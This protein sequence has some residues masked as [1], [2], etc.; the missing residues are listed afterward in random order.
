MSE[1]GRGL[2]LTLR[3]IINFILWFAAA[4]AVDEWAKKLTDGKRI[5]MKLA[6]PVLLVIWF[7]AEMELR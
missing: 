4:Y 5:M 2:L 7:L 6:Y 3:I 1:S